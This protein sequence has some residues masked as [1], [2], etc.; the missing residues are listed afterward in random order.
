MNTAL[1][2]SHE[3]SSATNGQL[4][5]SVCW[6]AID[7][8][9]DS[10]T[11]QAGSLFIALLGPN[12]DGHDH[13]ATSLKNGA[14]AALVHKIPAN[15][16]N[17]APLLLVK[18]TMI[19]L[20]SLA[21][22]A[23]NRS[24]ARIIAVTGSV[25]KTSTKEMLKL[26][27]GTS[28]STYVNQKNLNNHLGV[29]LSLARLPKKTKFAVFELG[30]N[31]AGEIAQLTNL[32]RPHIALIT[33][34]EAVHIAQFQS[35]QQIAKAKAEIFQ[36]VEPNG[37]AVLPRDNK[38]YHLLYEAAMIAK[39][40]NII[41]F[42][43]HLDS[44]AKLLDSKIDSNTTLISASFGCDTI[45]Y[46]INIPNL[47]WINNSLAAL[48][49][50]RSVGVDLKVAASSLIEMNPPK[51]RGN[52]KILSWD[53]GFIKIIDETYN[54][55]P[56]SMHAA[57]TTLGAIKKCHNIRSIVVLGDM[58]E[59]GKNAPSMHISLVK[60]II[61]NQ[62]DL[63]YTAGSLMRHL[64]EALPQDQQKCHANNSK[65]IALLVIKILKSGDVVMVKGSSNSV[66]KTV[67]KTIEQVALQKIHKIA[68]R[69]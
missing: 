10:R 39:I 36:G 58:L 64:H 1:W 22:A 60:S 29:P 62:I 13:V 21:K 23:R 67:I 46:Q 54:A 45:N 32:V 55:N 28:G 15:V 65:E 8:S 37:F 20:V 52:Q 25:G 34:V 68:T 5:G 59:L 30:M 49:V 17:D 24:D 14:V 40:T 3:A 38:Y 48:L 53:D 2:S 33:A 42:G 7:V 27:L 44:D 66:M 56:I 57:I 11:I 16:S 9:I 4:L 51:G 61:E 50:A 63:V 19:G 31:H 18:N 6:E 41:S 35:T 69:T 12:H 47:Y 26:A 43:S